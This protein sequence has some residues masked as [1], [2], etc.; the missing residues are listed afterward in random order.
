MICIW[1]EPV[2]DQPLKATGSAVAN[3]L[4]GGVTKSA[5]AAK[6]ADANNHLRPHPPSVALAKRWNG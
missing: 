1:E 2:Y 6:V 5:A 3:F 4:H